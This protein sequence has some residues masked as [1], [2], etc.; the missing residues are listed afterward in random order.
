M[1]RSPGR[2]NSTEYAPFYA[3]YVEEVEGDDVL[4]ILEAQL[5]STLELFR[6]LDERMGDHRYAPGKWSVKEVLG[7]LAD[8]ERVF[9]YRALCFAR[10]ET[11]GQPGFDEDLYVA[12]AQFGERT[13]ESIVEEYETVRRATLS[14]FRSIHGD[15]WHRIGNANGKPVS[16]RAIAFITAGHEAHHVR[17]LRERYLKA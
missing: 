8:G 10:G 12:Q 11:Q 2:P 15:V 9:V 7:H 13:L 6:A 1:T 14:F 17:V 4:G 3:G 16:V 5:A